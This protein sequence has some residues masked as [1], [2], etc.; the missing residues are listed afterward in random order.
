MQVRSRNGKLFCALAVV[1]GSVSM[2]GLE[3]VGALPTTPPTCTAGVP[4]VVGSGSRSATIVRT[5]CSGSPAG[6]SYRVRAYPAG[7][8]SATVVVDLPNGQAQREIPG[9]PNSPDAPDNRELASLTPGTAYRF[10]TSADNWAG[11]GPESG[12]STAAVPPFASVSTFAAR[13]YPDF[14]GA[15]P[16][17][18]QTSSWTSQITAGTLAPIAAIESL[19]DATYW[20]YQPPI[21]RLYWSYYQRIPDYTG[22]NYWTN[23]RRTGNTLIWVSNSFEASTEFQNKYGSLTDAQF[24]DR[25]YL[26]VLDRAAD[27]SGRAYWINKLATGTSRGQMMLNF[28]ESSEAINKRANLVQVV[29]VVSGTLLRVPTLTEVSDWDGDTRADVLQDVLGSPAYAARS[30]VVTTAPTPAAPNYNDLFTR[31]DQPYGWMSGDGA[32]SLR[33]PDGR[34]LWVFGDGA[35]GYL[36]ATPTEAD[37]TRPK[38]IRVLNAGRINQM[39]YVRNL[40]VV[41]RDGTADFETLLGSGTTPGSPQSW[42]PPRTSGQIS[43]PAGRVVEPVSGGSMVRMFVSDVGPNSVGRR[44][45]SLTTPGLAQTT[46]TDPVPAPTY[47]DGGSPAPISFGNTV[48]V[49][50]GYEYIYGGWTKPGGIFEFK[51]FVARVPVGSITDFSAWRYYSTGGTWEATADTITPV[52]DDA[53]N[54]IVKTPSGKYL[55]VVLRWWSSDAGVAKR[56]QAFSAASPAGPWL[57][58]T[59]SS[60]PRA[61]TYDIP[62]D[63]SLGLEGTYRTYLPQFHPDIHDPSD[64]DRILIGWSNSE[65]GIA[66]K[67]Y[68]TYGYRPRFTW[69]DIGDL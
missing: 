51:T 33:L 54:S 4:T 46:Y 49:D 9:V 34:D 12:L 15:A 30:G 27:P 63:A 60:T 23:K 57:A 41:T 44:I 69:I 65:P 47:S 21:T 50:G 62:E 17:S 32:G 39:G 45:L 52:A 2:V 8:S 35:P 10:T 31:F 13:Q 55:M 26:N 16:T 64:P 42:I 36:S 66:G 29:S 11:S 3:P 37:G 56:I 18:G 58:T 19:M 7:S 25:V 1:L 6:V 40:A 22:L 53:T 67:P 43:W 61:W 28:S 48:L 24:V 68:L 5:P 14:T 38:P 20:A 59:Q